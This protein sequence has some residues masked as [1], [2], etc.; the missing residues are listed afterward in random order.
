MF[1]RFWHP[2][3]WESISW[4]VTQCHWEQA[5]LW[6]QILTFSCRLPD[7]DTWTSTFAIKILSV[8][9]WSCTTWQLDNNLIN[10]WR[11]KEE[12]YRYS[13]SQNCNQS[14]V[15]TN[16]VDNQEY[17]KTGCGQQLHL[18]GPHTQ[19]TCNKYSTAVKYCNEWGSM[20]LRD[21]LHRA[22]PFL[23]I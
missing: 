9:T 17:P 15:Q 3:F 23:E 5:G 13:P 19:R 1:F 4:E 22:K 12:C 6:L 20:Q 2:W 18:P 16:P 11:N 8:L 7:T 21:W 14:T 10:K